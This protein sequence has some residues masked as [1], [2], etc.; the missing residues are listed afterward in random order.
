[1][2]VVLVAILSGLLVACTA[3][4]PTVV[5][6]TKEVMIPVPVRCQVRWPEKPK[7]DILKDGVLQMGFYDKMLWLLRESEEYRRYSASLEAALL[8]CADDIAP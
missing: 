1:M 2:K 7:S 6:V 5:T 4:E 3:T 8:V